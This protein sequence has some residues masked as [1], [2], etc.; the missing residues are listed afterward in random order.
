[1]IHIR[2]IFAQW[3]LPRLRRSPDQPLAPSTSRVNR[4]RHGF[5]ADIHFWSGGVIAP[6]DRRTR[7]SAGLLYRVHR[8]AIRAIQPLRQ[9]LLQRLRIDGLGE[10][11]VHA[12]GEALPLVLGKGA[13]GQGDDGEP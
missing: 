8:G 13:S 5:A 9:G 4:V 2:C 7:R 10:E 6:A 1:M 12:C 3:S 11:I